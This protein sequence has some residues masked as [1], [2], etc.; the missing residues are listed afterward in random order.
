MAVIDPQP[1]ATLLEDG[2]R[3]M[4]ICNACRY[5]EGYCAVFPAME[6]RLIFDRHDMG[7]LANLCHACGECYFACQFAPPHE[8]AVN[9]PQVLAQIRTATYRDFAWPAVIAAAF[10]RNA[11]GTALALALCIAGAMLAA[12]GFSGPGILAVTAPDGD[13]FKVVPHAVMA[14]AFG[15]AG[16]FVLTAL[17]VGGVNAWRSL[18]ET[19]ASALRPAAWGEAITD[20]LT[21]KYLSGDGDG[22][23]TTLLR[24][25]HARRIAHHLTFYG[26][27]LCFASTIAGTLYHYG[28]GWHAPYGLLSLP[29]GLGTLGGIGLVIGPP[30]LG[31]ERRRAD[32]ALFDKGHDRLA[33]ALI[34]LLFLSGLTGLGLLALRGTA[35][36]AVL[37]LLHLAVVM[38]LFLTIP[39]GKFVHPLYRLLALV[40]Y[41]LERRRP[42]AHTLGGD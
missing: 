14:G 19:A 5:C 12:V 42:P 16:L 3:Q 25:S 40:K 31:W 26:F 38:A 32:A 34:V 7:Y 1:A 36:M 23:A 39:Y 11:V 29:V 13:F 41:A 15:L 17:V 24:R 8:F 33:D 22:C 10:N 21:L 2:A 20:A 9:I 18:G 27:V 4:T 37:L 28:F 30:L 6:R 35:A